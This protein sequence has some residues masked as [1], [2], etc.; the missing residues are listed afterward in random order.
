MSDVQMMLWQLPAGR[1][2]TLQSLTDK[3]WQFHFEQ[4]KWGRPESW[5]LTR[6]EAITKA[7]AAA[8][9]G[10]GETFRVVRVSRYAVEGRAIPVEILYYKDGT[11]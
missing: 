4:Q 7:H 10:G 2:Y 1:E 9:R 5:F 3:G 8:A 6:D 11:N